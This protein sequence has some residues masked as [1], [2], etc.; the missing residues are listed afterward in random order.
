MATVIPTREFALYSL[1]GPSPAANGNCRLPFSTERYSRYKYGS[2]TAAE[3]FARALGAA[4]CEAHPEVAL[5]P[6]LTRLASRLPGND[7]IRCRRSCRAHAR[8]RI[9]AECL[10]LAVRLGLFQAEQVE[11]PGKSTE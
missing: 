11:L 6:R 2:V 3:T 7:V 9:V 8:Q 5:A 10:H 1:G 4:F